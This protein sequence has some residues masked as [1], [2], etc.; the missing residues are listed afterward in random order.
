M[1]KALLIGSG[2]CVFIGSA[3]VAM[4]LASANKST[5][6][7]HSHDDEGDEHLKHY[8]ND[9]TREIYDQLSNSY[10]KKVN[11]DERL[12]GVTKLRKQIINERVHGPNVLEI[13][14]GTGRNLD[15]FIERIKKKRDLTTVHLTDYSPKMI[16]Q[17]YIKYKKTEKKQKLPQSIIEFK[18]ADAHDLTSDLQK[19]H[20]DTV[21][22]TYGL[23][24]FENPEGVIR[25]MVKVCKPDGQI[26][27]LE[28]GRVSKQKHSWYLHTWLNSYLDKTSVT[29]AK[30]WG[31]WWNRDIDQIVDE[32]SDVLEV[33]EKKYYQ[34]GT[35][36]L[37]IARPKNVIKEQ[38]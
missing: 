36:Y 10:D 31:C 12:I 6:T 11:F 15:I 33:V 20:Y 13:A 23:C 4:T 9:E 8:S 28:H 24:S 5:C 29:R 1:R 37:I 35:C 19:Q 14:A 27:L 21:L 34:F 25:E 17:A 16:Q 2:A 22:D 26:I 3:Y 7:H 38:H 30:N 32:C 18:L